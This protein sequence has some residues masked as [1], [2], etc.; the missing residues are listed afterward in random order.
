MYIYF[1]V[2]DSSFLSQKDQ[3]IQYFLKTKVADILSA[4]PENI[5]NVDLHIIALFEMLVLDEILT[6]APICSRL[7]FEI[8]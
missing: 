1:T 3:S 6:E 4:M 8:P 7:S 2:S 5:C